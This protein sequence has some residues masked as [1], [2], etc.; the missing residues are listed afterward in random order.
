MIG[1]SVLQI[2][3]QFFLFSEIRFS[4][5][6]ILANPTTC[7]HLGMC[8]GE[9]PLWAGQ[10]LC[11]SKVHTLLEP[12]FHLSKPNVS[13]KNNSLLRVWKGKS[14]GFYCTTN[15][16]LLI[17]PMERTPFCLFDRDIHPFFVFESALQ[18]YHSPFFFFPTPSRLPPLP[19]IQFSLP[20]CGGHLAGH[21][22]TGRTR[23]RV[24]RNVIGVKFIY[25]RVGRL[26]L[27][28]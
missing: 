11:D 28:F 27:A 13:Q 21:Q 26:L 2:T 1:I 19:K 25:R 3:H 14:R 23:T 4:F 6:V 16:V 8:R 17:S 12:L 18:P 7:Q 15:E 10:H 24:L 22:E 20:T 5:C 9:G